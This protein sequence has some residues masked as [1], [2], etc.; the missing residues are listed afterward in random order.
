MMAT[1][2]GT[3]TAVFSD[4]RVYRFELRRRV[5][6][7]SEKLVTFVMLNPSTA[8]EFSDDPTIRRCIDF[9]RRWG[10]GRLTVVNL[11]PFRATDPKQLRTEHCDALERAS[12]DE[13]WNTQRRNWLHVEQ[14]AAEADRVVLAWG[15]HGDLLNAGRVIRKQLNDA[16]H[17]LYVLGLTRGGQ[18]KHPLY[19]AA[20]TGPWVLEEGMNA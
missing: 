18:P 13:R 4:D 6:M 14:A 17:D 16:G 1:S 19:V 9:A 11:F 20:E 2:W 3:A 15:A 5:D 8:D 7:T 12:G 10:F